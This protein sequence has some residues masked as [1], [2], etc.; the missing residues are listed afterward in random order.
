MQLTI[1]GVHGNGQIYLDILKAICGDTQGKSMIDLMCHH[2]PYTPL[3]GFEKRIYIDSQDR[4]IDHKDDQQLFI[5]SDVFLYLFENAWS[6]YDVMICSDGIEHLSKQAG[7]D[8]ALTMKL[9]SAKSVIFTPLGEW[10]ITDSDHP[11]SHKSGWMPNDFPGYA[12]IVLPEFHPVLETG[13]FFAWHTEDI[14]QDFDRV[15]NELKTKTWI[16]SL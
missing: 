6:K 15:V 1:P 7:F 13:A 14:Q 9:Q 8:L 11:D 3:L 10:M 5:K 2:A 16:K 4:G 12:T